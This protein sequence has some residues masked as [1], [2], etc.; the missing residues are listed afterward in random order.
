V[1]IGS[2]QSSALQGLRAA[3]AR[4]A[5][6]AHNVANVNTPGFQ[7][8]REPAQARPA[9]ASPPRAGAGRTTGSQPFALADADAAGVDAPSNTD[10]VTETFEQIA[11]VQAFKANLAAFRAA[12]EMTQS[13]LDIKA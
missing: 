6:S 12:D 8:T 9:N 3:T 10:L 13:V 2:T 7:P 5:Q 1:I 11:S 4:L